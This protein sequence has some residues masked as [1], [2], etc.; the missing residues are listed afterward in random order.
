MFFQAFCDLCKEDIPSAE[1]EDEDLVLRDAVRVTNRRTGIIHEYHRECYE[2]VLK[3]CCNIDCKKL[4]SVED[5]FFRKSRHRSRLSSSR[6][7]DGDLRRV[8]P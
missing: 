4:Q 6:Q 2:D 8:K 7:P 3:V 5:A 1:N